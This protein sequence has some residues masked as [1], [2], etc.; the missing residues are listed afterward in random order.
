MADQ[1]APP[2]DGR[3]RPEMARQGPAAEGPGGMFT[4]APPD[5]DRPPVYE[6]PVPSVSDAAAKTI[7]VRAA[8]ERQ[9]AGSRSPSA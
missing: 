1:A 3:E 2:G 4:W 8:A 9:Q 7:E 6:R 5:P